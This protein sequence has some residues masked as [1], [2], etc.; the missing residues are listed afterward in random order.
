MSD[1]NQFLTTLTSLLAGNFDL[2]NDVE[3][4]G[5]RI[6]LIAC[7]Q[8]AMQYFSLSKKIILDESHVTDVIL[9][10]RE[11]EI[12]TPGLLGKHQKW[13]TQLAK[14]EFSFHQLNMRTR[15]VGFI[16]SPQEKSY[17]ELTRQ[18]KKSHRFRW[19]KFGFGG[20]YE[21]ILIV[22]YLQSTSWIIP[23]KGN[24]F[25]PLLENISKNLNSIHSS[26]G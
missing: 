21:I 4:S 2:E 17:P 22:Y 18:I 7:S 12:L 11:D 5:R 23:R 6:P 19:L 3:I 20:W 9:C 26:G 15:F 10:W 24:D 16:V 25:L 1:Y 13:L 14:S 8:I